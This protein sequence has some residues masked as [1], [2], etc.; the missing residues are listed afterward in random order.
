M[1]VRLINAVCVLY[2]NNILIYSIV[3]Y[4]YLFLDNI[5]NCNLFVFYGRVMIE[6]KT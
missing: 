2:S 4:A 6:K 5:F 1:L 3:E